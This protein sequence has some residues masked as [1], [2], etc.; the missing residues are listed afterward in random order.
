MTLTDTKIKNL[1]PS[2]KL[3]R[4]YDQGGLCIVVR[5][6]GN[7]SWLYRYRLN[8]K[9]KT[10]AFGKY[11]AVSLRD[12]REKHQEA[13]KLLE[14]GK[15]P[16]A[17]KRQ[18]KLQTENSFGSVAAEWWKNQKDKWTPSHAQTI[19][20][21]LEKNALPWL[22]DRPINELTSREILQTLRR[23]EARNAF[24]TAKRVGNYISNIFI[25]AVAAGYADNNPASDINKALKVTPGRNLPAITDP[26]KI[27][28]LLRTIETFQGSFPVLCALKFAPLV[29]VRPGELRHAEWSEVDFNTKQWTI[30]SEKM[31]MNRD[32]IV[33][34]SRQAVEILEELHP[35]T[36]HGKYIFPS[37]R[38]STRPMSENTMN[39]ALKRLGYS[40]D[41]IVPHGFRTMAST[42]LHE[43]GWN[44][45]VVE[46]QLAHTDRN[47]VRGIYN[48]AEY[49]EDRK[50]M[51]QA[52]ADYL[53]GLRKG[54][55]IVPFRATGSKT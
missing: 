15:D 50:R 35:L 27:G 8:G 49:I 48:R 55:D 12:A 47:R 10:V 4:K 6:S 54:A 34:L 36:G 32:H 9:E 37:I 11:P 16:A 20:T 30:P 23:V 51:M 2:K 18:E 45:D 19:W 13:Q 33:P 22:K 39:A 41:E 40:K 43:L 21:R 3:Y 26:V 53:D 42:S 52:W 38:T 29:F 31:K 7:K 5:P 44:S 24:E 14:D 1:K 28:E 17:A 46:M 25:Y